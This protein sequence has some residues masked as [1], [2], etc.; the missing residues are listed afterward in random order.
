MSA[1]PRLSPEEAGDRILQSKQLLLVALGAS[2]SELLAAT[3]VIGNL[4]AALPHTKFWCLTDEVGAPAVLDHPALEEVWIAPDSGWGASI[5]RRF[6]ARRV[7]KYGI[8]AALSLSAYPPAAAAMGFLRGLNLGLLAGIDDE[9]E[10]PNG[11]TY[12]CVIPAPLDARNVVD[13]HLALLE[14]LGFGIVDRL[15]HLEVTSSQRDRA[16]ELLREAGVTEERPVLG[17]LPGGAPRHPERQWPASSYASVL[18]RAVLE[19]EYQAVLLGNSEDIPTL[20]G[21]QA[22]GKAPIPR[23][24]DLSFGEL[25]GVLAELDFFLTHDGDAVHMA[26]GVKVPS[27]FMFLSSPAWKWAPYGSQIAVWSEPDRGPTPAEVWGTLRPL[28]ER[29]QAKRISAGL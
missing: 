16:R 28:L 22:L 1:P 26:A 8:D 5:K 14:G 11:D 3:T 2:L 21:V 25:K 15:H 29:T 7:A 12:D 13:H 27:Y 18:Q 23:L 17:I 19:L 9:A 20:D 24:L 10:H 4:R 6:L